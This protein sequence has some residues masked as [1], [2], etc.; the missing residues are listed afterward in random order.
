MYFTTAY[1]NFPS[2]N[3]CFGYKYMLGWAS[4]VVQLAN[5]SPA[6]Q[7]TLVQPLGQDVPL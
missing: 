4:L 1:E 5:N 2:I 7:E 3:N 6:K